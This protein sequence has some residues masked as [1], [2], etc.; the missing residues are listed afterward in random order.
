M[1]LNCCHAI[2]NFKSVLLAPSCWAWHQRLHFPSGA[3][4]GLLHQKRD[5]RCCH[6]NCRQHGEGPRRRG[7]SKL[8]THT[9]GLLCSKRMDENEALCPQWNSR[10]S[11][12]REKPSNRDAP[13]VFHPGLH[14]GQG[15]LLHGSPQSSTC[16]R[17]RVSQS[18][19]LQPQASRR[20]LC[21]WDP[22]GKNTGVGCHAFLQGIFPTQEQ[23]PCLLLCRQILHRLGHQELMVK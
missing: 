8:R 4:M 12:L 7:V 6:G 18:T 16:L 13:A 9:V 3:F 11:F 14:A 1:C 22:P 2:C 21:P 19:S 10:P 15:G 5:L 20:L 23:N 17:K